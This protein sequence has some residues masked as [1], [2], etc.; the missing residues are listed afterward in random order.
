MH[1]LGVDLRYAKW[2]VIRDLFGA[3]CIRLICTATVP[4]TLTQDTP[5][6][7]AHVDVRCQIGFAILLIEP[8]PKPIRS[9][10]FLVL[11][12]HSLWGRLGLGDRLGLFLLDL[13]DPPLVRFN[14]FPFPYILLDVYLDDLCRGLSNNIGGK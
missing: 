4:R 2:G 8:D 14:L 9:R 7:A 5:V 12:G 6:L 13:H 1:P 11:C 3:N 10:P